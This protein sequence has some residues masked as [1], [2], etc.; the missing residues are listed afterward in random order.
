M[1]FLRA[2]PIKKHLPIIYLDVCPPIIYLDVCVAGNRSNR[3]L[4]AQQPHV[5]GNRSN[6]KCQMQIRIL[7]SVTE[8]SLFIILSEKNLF[9]FSEEFSNFT[10]LCFNITT[11]TTTF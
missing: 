2:V 6:R 7:L 5:A 4:L 10:M 9:G 1:T 3:M 11:P 8:Q